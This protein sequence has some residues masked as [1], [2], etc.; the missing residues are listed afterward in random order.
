[1]RSIRIMTNNELG[2]LIRRARKQNGLTQD[3]LATQLGKSR[4][5]VVQ[6][7][8]GESYYSGKGVG[9]GLEPLMCVR[10]ADT[11]NLDP[12]DVLFAA[13]VPKA[14]WPNF[15]NVLAKSVSVRNV[16]ITSLTLEQA[17]LVKGIV[18]ELKKGN[19]VNER[20]IP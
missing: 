11:L 13:G 10:I 7:E 17:R 18:E 2:T 6:L 5:W 14:E 16:D 1:M 12:A 8:K 9:R 20:E 3:E 4:W 15:S 19:T